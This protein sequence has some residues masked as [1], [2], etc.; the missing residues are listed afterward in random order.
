MA[1]YGPMNLGFAYDWERRGCSQISTRR[2]DFAGSGTGLLRLSEGLEIELSDFEGENATL[3]GDYL[4]QVVEIVIGGVP[5]VLEVCFMCLFKS[6]SRI[7]LQGSGSMNLFDP[8]RHQVDLRKVEVSIRVLGNIYHMADIIP[9]GVCF[10]LLRGRCP[11]FGICFVVDR[12]LLHEL[13]S[14]GIGFGLHPFAGSPKYDIIFEGVTMMPV[15]LHV[16][17]SCI[18]VRFISS[19]HIEF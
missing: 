19:I 8:M 4:R 18:I 12:S 10:A 17:Q 1:V 7:L 9:P 2:E 13:R 11:S 6:L 15:I 14:H 3:K 5:T 16:A